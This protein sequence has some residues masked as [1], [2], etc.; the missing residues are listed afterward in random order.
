[1]RFTLIPRHQRSIANC[2]YPRDIKADVTWLERTRERKRRIHISAI[3]P[4]EICARSS[5]AYSGR[6]GQRT[7][8]AI[9]SGAPS[10]MAAADDR[11]MLASTIFERIEYAISRVA[12]YAA[13]YARCEQYVEH[14]HDDARL[15]ITIASIFDSDSRTFASFH[16]ER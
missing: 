11:V 15:S 16:P 5:R 2:L 13:R 8:A 14:G 4:T 10:G 1:V 9:P 3:S 12:R 6:I 7:Q